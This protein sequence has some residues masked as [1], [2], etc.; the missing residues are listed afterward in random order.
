MH[1]GVH[2]V[3]TGSSSL[4]S[5]FETSTITKSQ[6]QSFLGNRNHKSS[7]KN[8]RRSQTTDPK[9]YHKLRPRKPCIY[10]FP[11]ISPE[12]KNIHTRVANNS[13][14]TNPGTSTGSTNSI[15]W[16]KTCQLKRS[17]PAARPN[18]QRAKTAHEYRINNLPQT[19]VLIH[20]TQPN[21]S[22]HATGG[23]M[24]KKQQILTNKTSE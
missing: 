15:R 9:K 3:A 24:R 12:K 10:E 19:P 22:P 13:K 21:A 5:P 14:P 2:E 11:N 20:N 17:S 8:R 4:Y 23:M 18:L 6:F 16:R 1:V 7:E